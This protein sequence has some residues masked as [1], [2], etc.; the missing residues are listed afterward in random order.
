MGICNAKG[1]KQSKD[2]EED[3]DYSKHKKSVK[4]R[5]DFNL[6]MGEI[7]REN[8]SKITKEYNL[9]SPP[10]G[11]GAFGEVRRAINRETGITRAVKIIQ[12]SGCPEAEIKRIVKEVE[13]LKKLDHPNIIKVFEFFI[14]DNYLYIVTD[15]CTG[16]E[17][18]DKIISKKFFSEKEASD[19]MHQVLSAIVYCHNNNIVHRDLKPENILLESERSNQLKV[20][21]FGTSRV[22]NSGSEMAQRLGTVSSSIKILALLHCT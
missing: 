3:V 11:K 7:V 5:D 13:I 1:K 14:D 22:Y 2:E 17:L 15:L 18:F 16:G 9:L 20:I 19:T 21:D 4:N 10:L 6:G 12:K 8:K